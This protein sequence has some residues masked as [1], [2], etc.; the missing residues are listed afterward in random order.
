MVVAWDA[1]GA[2]ASSDPPESFTVTDWAETLGEFL[3]SIGIQNA[4]IVGLSWGG[5]L[6]QQRVSHARRRDGC[7]CG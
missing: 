4:H 2:G 5:L 7:R 6:A 3:D 1:P